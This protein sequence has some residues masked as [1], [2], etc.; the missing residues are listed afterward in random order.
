LREESYT[1]CWHTGATSPWLHCKFNY[2]ASCCC[3][4]S[5]YHSAWALFKWK[6]ER[7]WVKCKNGQCECANGKIKTQTNDEH[8]ASVLNKVSLS[9]KNSVCYQQTCY[10]YRTHSVN[11]SQAVRKFSPHRG[12]AWV[13]EY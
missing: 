8:M 11:S 9:L 5:V 4:K 13:M 2:N 3:R 10:E 12:C 6:L 7:K 1:S